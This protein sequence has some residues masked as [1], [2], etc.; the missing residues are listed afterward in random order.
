MDSKFFRAASSLKTD[1]S[2]RELTTR[3][4]S[5]IDGATEGIENFLRENESVARMLVQLMYL[6]ADLRESQ[7]AEQII[8]SVQRFMHL[9]IPPHQ[10][11]NGYRRLFQEILK[12]LGCKAQSGILDSFDSLVDDWGILRD[13]EL[14]LSLRRVISGCLTIGLVNLYGYEFDCDAVLEFLGMTTLHPFKSR[15]EMWFSIIKLIRDFMK[16]GHECFAE[17]SIRPLIVRNRAERVWLT[18]YKN[19]IAELD[20][21]PVNPNFDPVSLI[22]RMDSLYAEGNLLCTRRYSSIGPLNKE[23]GLR[24]TQFVRENN[25][26][27]HRSPPFS[28]LLYGKPGTGKSTMINMLGAYFQMAMTSPNEHGDILDP[29]LTWDPR[30]NLYTRSPEEEYWSGFK[31]AKQWFIVLDD[32]ARERKEQVFQGKALSIKE[33][34]TV[35][36]SIGIATNQASLENKGCIPLLPKLV[37]ATTNQKDLH[38]HVAVSEPGAILRRFPIVVEPIVKPEFVGPDGDIVVT[39]TNFDIWDFRVEKIVRK[40]AVYT[41]ELVRSEEGKEV[42]TG[43]EFSR[44]IRREMQKFVLK[45]HKVE[46]S[47]K[48]IPKLCPHNIVTTYHRCLQCDGQ[49]KAQALFAPDT[50]I[51]EFALGLFTW[52]WVVVLD[53]CFGN[54]Y[55]AFLLKESY[56]GPFISSWCRTKMFASV[57]RRY[58]HN[59]LRKV[60]MQG[61]F[62]I[63]SPKI[64]ETNVALNVLLGIISIYGCSVLYKWF[65]PPKA[66]Y[67]AQADVWEKNR[68]N[69]DF[70]IPRTS[71]PGNRSELER[72]ISKSIFKLNVQRDHG[73][74]VAYCLCI[75]EGEYVTVGHIFG[76]EASWNCVADFMAAHQNASARRAFVLER[77]QVEFLQNDLCVFRTRSIPPRK[78]IYKFLPEKVDK[79]GRIARQ[80]LDD[81]NAL[82]SVAVHTTSYGHS[83][84]TDVNGKVYTGNYMHGRRLEGFPKAGDCGSPLLHS[85]HFGDFIAGIHVAGQPA[86]GNVVFSQLSQEM[87]PAREIAMSGA[88]SM[89]DIIN[90]S[91]SSGPLTQPYRKGLH[92]WIE[93]GSC[94]I[95]GS[96]TGRHTPVSKVSYTQ[97]CKDIKETFNFPCEFGKPVMKPYQNTD[98][99]WINPFTIA[100]SQQADISPLFRESILRECVENYITHLGE[101]EFF[102]IIVDEQA[103]I[104]GISGVDFI[105]RLPM[106]TSGG[107]YFPGCKK[108]YFTQ[109]EDDEN[110]YIPNEE[111]TDRINHI[112]AA[113]KLGERA[114]IIFQGTLKDEPTKFSKIRS[115]KTRVFTACDVAFSIVVRKQY[116][117]VTRFIMQH[118][119]RTECAVGMNCYSQIWEELYDY[120]TEFGEDRIIAGDYSAFDKNMPAIFILAAFDVLN[121]LIDRYDDDH[122]NRMIRRGIA[123]DI[124]FP[125]V[126]M[127][128]DVFQFYGGNSSGHPLTVIINSIVNS[129]YMRY[130]YQALGLPL[131]DFSSTVRLMTLGDDNIMGSKDDRF[132]HTAIADVLG[133]L[134]VPYTMADKDSKSVPFI[135]IQD[136]DFLKRTF[137]MVSGRI[138][139]PLAQTS[140]YK[141]LCM[142]LPKGNIS[143]E[144]QIAQCCLAAAMEM[145]L[146]GEEIYTDFIRQLRKI[147][148]QYEFVQ[149]FLHDRIKFT[150]NQW[151][152]WFDDEGPATI[153]T[154]DSSEEE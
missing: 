87:F 101:V 50:N 19:I 41:H 70:I 106:S 114:N 140:I 96:Y 84:Y 153:T 33:V 56:F 123:T 154:L 85:S 5:S 90:G 129:L 142:Y 66:K 83:S 138:R 18:L 37:V 149:P 111:V 116:L 68:A 146:H 81:R 93:H 152:E 7:N 25:V 127:N 121:T 17:K 8:Y 134:G 102:P 26:C 99:E 113:Y 75:R 52:Y 43:E 14:M 1:A 147:L 112:E 36:N 55:L 59:H 107:F 72:T 100:C 132:N 137:R 39:E 22:S 9:Y 54:L 29:S 108:R 3:F 35:V 47:M 80:L 126:N 115:G 89:L 10:I 24:R 117:G 82:I 71:H 109:D 133:S 16:V 150:Y 97:I 130:A 95:V 69:E 94:E 78:P 88:G 51:P 6:F 21:I 118:N 40:D 104:N 58:I 42:M 67:V 122:G 34:I 143:E 12:T 145:V 131:M 92:H 73:V 60:V 15:E 105:N 139:A 120:L 63:S 23:L 110:I 124:A 45:Q 61:N 13:S 125:I 57:R 30:V 91:R 151:I 38:A 86:T 77:E 64:R 79:A 103:A 74:E 119:L 4:G 20:A 98:G 65:R 28:I 49:L 2:L 62:L 76:D 32:L 135:H 46:Q 48:E 31:G 144:E 136:A 11:V 44:Y 141:S 27:S 148:N 53:W 128:G